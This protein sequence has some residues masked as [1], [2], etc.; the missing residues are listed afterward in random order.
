M[1]TTASGSFLTFASSSRTGASWGSW[2]NPSSA[3]VS[4]N[5][6]A[7]TVVG[8][9]IDYYSDWLVARSPSGLSIPSGATIN[10]IQISI[11]RKADFDGTASY[12]VADSSLKI[13]KAMTASGTDKAATSTYW[14]TTD[15]TVT[16]G[17]SADL[18][19]LSWTDTDFGSGF[20][21]ALS[22]RFSDPAELTGGSA[23]RVDC[24]T[25]S[26]TYTSTGR[27]RKSVV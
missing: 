27:D 24:I 5:R 19:G 13:V 26:I 3:Q 18:W 12:F 17:S 11:E 23:A 25:W 2:T 8:V 6:Y 14:T 15:T 1:S 9:G 20:G 4:D 22:A 7:T 21:V 10:G 16:Y